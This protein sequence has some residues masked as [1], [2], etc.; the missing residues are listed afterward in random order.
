MTNEYRE[1]LLKYFTGNIEEE[2][3]YDTPQL[4]ILSSVQNNLNDYMIQNVENI[5]LDNGIA[6]FSITDYLKSDN[7]DKLLIYGSYFKQD[8]ENNN[9]GFI[10]IL[11]NNMNIID[12]M[13]TFSS[14]TP[15]R[16]FIMLNIAEDNTIY[17]VDD[18]IDFTLEDRT[19]RF[20][21]LNDII[22]SGNTTGIYQTV[23]KTSYY[24]PVDYNNL[25]FS[26]FN[27][28]KNRL[29]KKYG[30]SSYL[31]IGRYN[32]SQTGV[33]RL[34]V[35]VGTE[36]EWNL[37]TYNTD[38]ATSAI[39]TYLEWTD[40]NLILKV[41]G[42]NSS[43]Y[44]EIVLSDTTFNLNLSVPI[45][46]AISSICMQSDTNTYISSSVT[47]YDNQKINY[48]IYKVDYINKILN[49]IYIQEETLEY[50]RGN[51][52]FYLE[53]DNIFFRLSNYSNSATLNYNNYIGVI[54]DDKIFSINVGETSRLSSSFMYVKNDYNL[55]KLMIQDT[56]DIVVVALVYNSNNYN[57]KSFNNI[58]SLEPNNSILYNVNNEPIFARN[59]YNKTISNNITQSTIEVP[60]TYLNNDNIAIQSL[61]SKNNNIIVSNN[62]NITKNI[63]ETL[64]INFFNTIMI[65]NNNDKENPVTNKS[66]AIRLNNSI[67]NLLDYDETKITK[68][69]INYEDSTT[70]TIDIKFN[71]KDG[72]MQTSFFLYVDKKINTIDL[73][74]NDE[75]TI[76]QTITGT[77]EIGKNY[78]VKQDVTVI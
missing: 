29:L 53:N 24:F 49:N 38:I 1:N 64:Y 70:K 46:G 9:Y 47:D 2:I 77:F 17:G 66:G 52:I 73:I 6:N 67:S 43:V 39:G 10:L 48:N 13:T 57:G 3:G 78:T 40:D 69:K 5:R 68:A 7:S 71:F 60:N 37:Y 74:S 11:D 8:D 54:A 31:F 15:F 36:N 28:K 35:N 62:V 25:F 45:T 21:M 20:V 23:L 34:D 41:G 55:Y 12:L 14:G 30:S 22:G 51:L 76:Y 63:Y 58:N 42:F 75:N 19:Y 65:Q 72:V 59:L 50:M 18:D 61:L 27:D 56:N 32:T 16:N 4:E 44:Y 33:L 26:Y